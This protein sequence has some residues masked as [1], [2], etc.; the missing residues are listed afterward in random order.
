MNHYIGLDAHSA[1][2]TFVCLD[3]QGSE[4]AKTQIPTSERQITGFL[5]SLKGRKKLVFEESTMSKWLHAITHAQV[6]EVIV[7]NPVFLSRKRGP[8]ND[9]LDSLHL[10][11]E[12]R[13]GHLETVFHSSDNIYIPIRVLVSNYLDVVADIVRDKNRLKSLY[14]SQGIK[15]AGSSVYSDPE[16]IS[17][18]SGDF[19]P[20]CAETLMYKLS[21][22]EEIKTNYIDQFKNNVKKHKILRLL[23]TIPQVD[24]VRA[25]V[26]AAYTCDGR[27]FQSKHQYW[28]YT[29]LVRYS[30]ESD[31]Q[32]YGSKKI[33]GRSE[34]KSVY[35]GMAEGV[36]R[37]QNALRKYYD[38]LRSKGLDHKKARTAVA[39]KMAAIVLSV[40]KT[41]KPYDDK[42]EE[43]IKGNKRTNKS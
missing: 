10:A 26:I 32:F 14:R 17:K 12:L 2:C 7:C 35:I 19:E 39:R 18:L 25:N 6:D 11:H 41:E 22:S 30:Q 36:L 33:R 43:K 20:F 21:V 24:A 1:T 13:K 42:F 31:G 27:R 23:D 16:K 29:G 9:Y 8:K 37:S 15:E 38:R 40:F 5:R 34:L 28:A 3:Q 4:T